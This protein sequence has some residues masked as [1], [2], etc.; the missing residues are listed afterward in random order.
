MAEDT[1]VKI[2]DGG[3]VIIPAPIRKQ[4]G[5]EIGDEL[6]LR[7]EQGELK[8]LTKRQA[9]EQAQRLLQKYVPRNHSL[10]DELIAER[11]NETY[12]E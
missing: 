6:I 4:L 3:R 11:R 1:T 2:A 12:N 10:S 8:L 5:I 9:V 7:M